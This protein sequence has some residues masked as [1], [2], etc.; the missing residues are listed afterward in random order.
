[1]ATN[2]ELMKRLNELMIQGDRNTKDIRSEMRTLNTKLEDV[3]VKAAEK[4]SN[5]NDKMKRLE[6]RLEKIEKN[7]DKTK[8][9]CDERKKLA[10]EQKVRV[11]N[12]KEAA[13]LEIDEE[14][15]IIEEKPEKWSELIKRSQDQEKKKERR[16]YCKRKGDETKALEEGDLRNGKR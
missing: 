12:F 3:K 9:K 16:S 10:E 11:N 5:D 15:E 2:D 13:G 1:M 4:E 14:P 7:L 8:Y 6:S